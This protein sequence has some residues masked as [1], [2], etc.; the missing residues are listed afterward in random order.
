MSTSEDW[1]IRLEAAKEMREN[2][3]VYS[4]G[5][6]LKS[7]SRWTWEEIPVGITFRDIPGY[8][9]SK[10][11]PPGLDKDGLPIEKGDAAYRR[12][13]EAIEAIRARRSRDKD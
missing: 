13:K 12:H 1:R 5:K 9:P 11:P 10:C 8:L 4:R 3:Y 7:I 2:G 6:W